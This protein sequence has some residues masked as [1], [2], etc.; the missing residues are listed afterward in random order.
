[1]PGKSMPGKPPGSA[2]RQVRQAARFGKPPGPCPAGRQ[3]W[4]AAW[5]RRL[6]SRIGK[7]GSTRSHRRLDTSARCG[8]QVCRGAIFQQ[9]ILDDLGSAESLVDPAPHNRPP[10]QYLPRKVPLTLERVRLVRRM[11]CTGLMGQIRLA[12]D[13][14][15][16]RN[17]RAALR[18]SPT[19]STGHG[20]EASINSEKLPGVVGWLA[21]LG[22]GRL[23]ILR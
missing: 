17:R 22:A 10:N 19:R 13:R 3:V 8:A 6:L 16:E 21:R 18:T 12:L 7:S 5:L 2:S 14:R 4:Q 1:M 11:G 9:K 15:S 23:S 20:K